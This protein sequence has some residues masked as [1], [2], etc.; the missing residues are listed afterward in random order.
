MKIAASALA[1]VLVLSASSTTSSAPASPGDWS[2]VRPSVEIDVAPTDQAGQFEVNATIK[3]LRS[4]NVLSEPKLL[5]MAG[6]A[7]VIH[8]GSETG[9]MVKLS[10]LVDPA[11]STASYTAEVLQA[12]EMVSSHSASVTLERRPAGD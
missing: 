12:D 2:D 8:V 9:A 1:L 7:A 11:A 5:T 3:D 6:R 10:V 4:G